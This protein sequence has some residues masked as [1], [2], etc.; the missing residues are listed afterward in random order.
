MKKGYKGICV[1]AVASM[2][3]MTGC[4][5]KK[6]DYNVSNFEGD[7]VME[8]DSTGEITETA[9]SS[10]EAAVTE[11]SPSVSVIAQKLEIPESAHEELNT[12]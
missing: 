7:S 2:L 1:L 3:A 11:Q 9:G 12:D 8:Y 5:D 6:V 4:G 10:D